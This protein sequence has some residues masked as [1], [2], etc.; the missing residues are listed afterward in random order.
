[1]TPAERL[2]A[3][4]GILKDSAQEGA[5]AVTA[6]IVGKLGAVHP[7]LAGVVSAL[8]QIAGVD[9]LTGD[10]TDELVARVDKLLTQL[11]GNDYPIHVT[12]NLFVKEDRRP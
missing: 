5:R 4:E 2:E 3:V 6:I 11:F 8:Y 9:K 12:A 10:I 7:A 1:M